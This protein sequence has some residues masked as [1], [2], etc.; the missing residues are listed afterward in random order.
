M[1]MTATPSDEL[2]KATIGQYTA[3]NARNFTYLEV[4]LNNRGTVSEETNKSIMTGN[5]AYYANS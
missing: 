2:P 1:N 3:E 5:K 4:L